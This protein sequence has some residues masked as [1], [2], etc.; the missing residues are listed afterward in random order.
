[1]KIHIMFGTVRGGSS[2]LFKQQTFLEHKTICKKQK[3][4]N[5]HLN[6][7]CFISKLCLDS[8]NLYKHS[9]PDSLLLGFFLCPITKTSASTTSTST[10]LLLV[11]YYVILV[12][13][14]IV[15]QMYNKILNHLY[16]CDNKIL[17]HQYKCDN[18][19]TYSA[20]P[21][22]LLFENVKGKK[23]YGNIAP[24]VFHFYLQ[25]EY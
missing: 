12:Q 21:E 15:R 5:T 18:K 6:D 2:R 13:C 20:E 3:T 25:K 24:L 22:K 16:K 9:F 8:S 1:M 11:N 23:L 14:T 10:V 17:N 19:I 7:K 4:K